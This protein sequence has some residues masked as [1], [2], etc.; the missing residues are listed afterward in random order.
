[1]ANKLS[2]E[3]ES[4]L[5]TEFNVVSQL[6]HFAWGVMVMLLANLFSSHLSVY[7]RMSM[8]FIV[9]I[10]WILYTGIKEFWYDEK[11]EIPVVRGSSTLDFWV[12]SGSAIVA[13][14]LIYIFK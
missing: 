2:P 13:M 9:L 14:G 10:A 1:M 11:Y 8:N 5:I 7:D 12:Q 3:D 6:S 4:I